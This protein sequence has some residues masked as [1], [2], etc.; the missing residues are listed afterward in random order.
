MRSR[1]LLR[2]LILFSILLA[3]FIALR[4]A[5]GLDLDPESLQQAVADMGVWGPL[6][7]VGIVAFR[8]P[9]GLPSGLVLVGGG[10]AF[11]TLTATLCGAIGLTLSAIVYFLAARFTGRASIE[12]R[13]PARMRPFLD[14]AGT[15]IGALFL[16]L[17]TAYPFGP[18]TMFHLLA[19]LTGISLI[20]FVFAVGTGALARS[21][22]FTFF[23][24]QLVDG[25]VRGLLEAS[26]LMALALALPLL[27]P[28]TRRWLLDAFRAARAD[29]G[30]SPPIDG[31]PR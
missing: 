7:F 2:A 22:L 21:A 18:I 27:V 23:G 17:G 16:A 10:L 24:S 31:P 28:R 6:A 19:G 11:G 1:R 12:A 26:A 15:R 3:G 29:S 25:G 9:L 14:L 13:V 4:R 30:T 8:V 5:L 20:V